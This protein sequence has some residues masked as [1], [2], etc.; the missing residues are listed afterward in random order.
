[1]FPAFL[2]IHTHPTILCRIRRRGI[3]RE[4]ERERNKREPETRGQMAER[5]IFLILKSRSH[6]MCLKGR[7]RT[8]HSFSPLYLNALLSVC[9]G[10]CKQNTAVCLPYFSVPDTG[11][12]QIKVLADLFLVRACFLA[13]RWL[14]PFCAWMTSSLYSHG[15]RE[16]ER[17]NTLSSPSSQ[18]TNSIM[19]SLPS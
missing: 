19:V 10:C 2:N 13:G 15:E 8:K 16:R 4:E 1:M 14:S 17:Q 6:S 9:W 11:K 18:G 5:K 7:E 12:L 3:R